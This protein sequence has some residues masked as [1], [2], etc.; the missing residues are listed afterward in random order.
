MLSGGR[1][2]RRCRP[3]ARNSQV[4]SAGRDRHELLTDL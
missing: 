3:R 4:T 2:A 1:G